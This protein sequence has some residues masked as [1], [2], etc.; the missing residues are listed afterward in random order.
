MPNREEDRG[1]RAPQRSTESI[2]WLHTLRY[3]LT[4]ACAHALTLTQTQ[5]H[6]AELVNYWWCCGCQLDVKA[7]GWQKLFSHQPPNS[8]GCLIACVCVR[9]CARVFVCVHLQQQIRT[10]IWKKC[11]RIIPSDWLGWW[12]SWGHL[13]CDWLAQ[14]SMENLSLSFDSCGVEYC[15]SVH[16]CI[17][18]PD[19]VL[20]MC[21]RYLHSTQQWARTRICAPPTWPCAAFCTNTG[22][23]IPHKMTLKNWGQLSYPIH[24]RWVTAT[25][26]LKCYG[27]QLILQKEWASQLKWAQQDWKHV[28]PLWL[29]RRT[30][31]QPKF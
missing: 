13:C 15:M 2:S 16:V 7:P 1:M 17:E 3:T 22:Y 21:D 18:F 28:V 20:C 29:K 19:S 30:E 25:S 14:K 9:V 26:P 11:E 10:Q 8:A 23:L 4:C 27:N 24:T 12:H 31:P 6:T 5:K